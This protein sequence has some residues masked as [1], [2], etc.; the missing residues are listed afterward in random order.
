[1]KR[2]DPTKEA[3][4]KTAGLILGVIA[5][6]L[7]MLFGGHLLDFLNELVLEGM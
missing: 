2:I 4:L 5:S 7:L 6:F 1:M 3:A